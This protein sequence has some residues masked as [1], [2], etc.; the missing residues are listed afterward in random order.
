MIAPYIYPVDI[1]VWADREE[2][3][4]ALFRELHEEDARAKDDRQQKPE[5]AA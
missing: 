1:E 5:R 2:E 3:L 4:E